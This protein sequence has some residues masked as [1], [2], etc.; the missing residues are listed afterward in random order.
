MIL[1][2]DTATRWAGLALHDGTAVIA[3][4]GWRCINTHTIELA[5]AIDNMLQRTSLSPA[6]LSA[7]TVAI[8]PGSYTGL[9]VGLALAKGLALANGIPLIGVPTL[10]ILATSFGRRE[11]QLIVVVEA[12]RRRISA[13]GYIWQEPA[14]WALQWGPKNNTW[15]GLLAKMKGSATFAGEISP[16]AVKQIR[17]ADNQF[18]VALPSRS[19]RRAGCLA[20]MGWQRLRAKTADNASTIAPTYLRGP[21]GETKA[22]DR[23]QKAG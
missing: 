17:A 7:I 14:G 4:Y 11:G 9:R 21:A 15:D 5:P 2:I 8:G 19:V 10:D 6:D 22:E 13:A 12:G 16:E 23:N 1:A 20:E 18:Q 3:E